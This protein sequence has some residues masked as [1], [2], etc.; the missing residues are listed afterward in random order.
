MENYIQANKDSWN[1]Q[2][3][4]HI[5][6]EFYDMP[7]FLE[8]KSSLKEIELALLGNVDGKRILHLQCHFGQD[9]FSLARMGANCT[10]VDLSDAA[11][12]K[13][14]EINKDLKL[15]V[16]F[17]CCDLYELPQFLE[18]EFDMVF[19]TYGTIGWLPDLNKWAKLIGKY[20]KTGGKFVMADFHPVVWMFNEEMSQITYSYFNENPIVETLTGTYADRGSDI[21]QKT[22]SW[23]HSLGELFSALLQNDLNLLDFQEY[24]YSPYSCFLNMYEV[25]NGKYKFSKLEKDIP[26]VYS[27]LAEKK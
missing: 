25:E 19:T 24:N 7:S 13:A 16:N 2:T 11:I 8:G 9:T 17:I 26:I 5:V 21:V 12:K 20:L 18:G 27:I 15:D 1:K 4:V 6:S 23:N 22:I 10:G 14:K 3:A